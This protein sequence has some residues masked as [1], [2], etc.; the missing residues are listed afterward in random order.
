[1]SDE[2]TSAK[3]H[4]PSSDTSSRMEFACGLSM[5]EGLVAKV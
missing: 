4:I 1:L 5:T 2:G 3:F